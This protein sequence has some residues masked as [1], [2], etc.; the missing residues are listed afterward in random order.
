MRDQEGR[1]INMGAGD[2]PVDRRADGRPGNPDRIV[3]RA[4][5]ATENRS[6]VP[7]NFIESGLPRLRDV[8]PR[9]ATNADRSEDRRIVMAVLG[10]L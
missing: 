10:E 2:K 4:L 1:A 7:K 8:Q 3:S 9:R 6:I 5:K